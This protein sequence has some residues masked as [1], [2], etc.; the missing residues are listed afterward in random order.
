[1][2]SH[3]N[4][5]NEAFKR[6]INSNYVDKTGLINIVNSTIG[7]TNNL[8]CISRPRRF[9]KSYAAQML[10]AYYDCTV[11]S[12]AMFAGYEVAESDNYSRY[13]NA[14]NVI[15]IDVTSFI[16][17]Y[18][19]KKES[20]N[21]VTDDIV[22]TIKNEVFE[23]YPE[24]S[25]D[26]ELSECLMQVKNISGRQFVFIIDEWDAIVREASD[27]SEAQESY[28]NLLRELFKN[29]NFTPYVIAAAY[30]TGIL[31]I[32]KDG[33]ESAIS[34]FDEYTILNPGI[35]AKYTGFT[36]DEVKKLCQDANAHF[37]TMKEWYDGYSFAEA[38]SV[39]NPY[40]VMS[41]LR[42]KSYESFW[43]KTTAAESLPA[44]INLNFEGL[45]DD[46]VRLIAGEKLEV[47]VNGFEN[48]VKSF[49]NKDDVITLLIHLGY[50]AYDNNDRTVRIPNKEVQ[51]EFQS[52]L[53]T[54]GMTELGELVNNSLKLLKDTLNCNEIEVSKRIEAIRASDYAPNFYNDE[55][56]LRYVIKFAYIVCVDKY[57][58]IQELPSGK[59]VADV[60]FIPKRNTP[61]P[62]MIVEL[63]WNKSSNAAIKQIKDRNYPAVLEKYGGEILLVGINYDEKS[64]RH[65]CKIEKIMK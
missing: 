11:D 12:K 7:T 44:Y 63:K 13:I 3:F 43:Q 64:K 4:P 5:G 54:S 1:M 14:F 29:G 31:P 26:S 25:R 21:K 20:L 65:T 41:S 59:G 16:S 17:K 2:T 56:A 58:D 24:I 49:K 30:M 9:G 38:K 35:F 48:D 6:I 60:V 46:I 8:T 27:D 50:L 18:K 10:S 34:D 32:K 22:S 28:F 53:R 52:L 36:E 61:D 37:E 62:A 45:Q 42:M 39:Y 40:S 15:Y 19:R 57:L 55:Q 33:T 51:S 47:N 23:R